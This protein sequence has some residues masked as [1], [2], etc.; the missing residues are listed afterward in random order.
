MSGAALD[1][2]Y[3]VLKGDG[4]W[5]LMG[6][7]AGYADLYPLVPNATY[8]VVHKENDEIRE[9]YECY[10]GDKKVGYYYNWVK[11]PDCQGSCYASCE[12]PYFSCDPDGSEPNS[13]SCSSGKLELIVTYKENG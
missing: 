8:T 2:N 7:C 9:S 13:V 1:I 3:E 5:R 10:S 6:N 12:R 11:S 4:T